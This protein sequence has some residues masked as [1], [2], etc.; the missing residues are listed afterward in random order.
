MRRPT[1]PEA[2][3]ATGV[4]TLSAAAV[5]WWQARKAGEA[6]EAF[7][8]VGE[9]P[10]GSK[11]NPY[12]LNVANAPPLSRRVAP[13][14][15]SAPRDEVRAAIAR[16]WAKK[17]GT[18]ASPAAL[19]ILMAQYLHETGGGASAWNYNPA[20][21]KATPSWSGSWTALRGFE[22]EGG[23]RVYRMMAWRAFPALQPGIDSWM[24]L[25]A[26]RYFAALDAAQRGDLDGFAEG[27]KARGYFTAGLGAYKRA[28]KKWV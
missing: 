20:G 21:V 25:L 27:L 15:T 16:A 12:P 8:G 7:D 5:G 18:V 6:P 17:R 2:L 9:G 11:T 28:L 24:G 13:R 26:G 22:N 19:D 14:K 1:T 10:I 4:V 3:V 23:K